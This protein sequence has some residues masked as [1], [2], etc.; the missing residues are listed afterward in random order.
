[1]LEVSCSLRGD[2]KRKGERVGG[3][4]EDTFG[5]DGIVR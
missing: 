3:G 1:M 4:G 2:S 5:K